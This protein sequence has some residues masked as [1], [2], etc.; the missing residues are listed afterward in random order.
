MNTIPPADETELVKRLSKGDES[1]FGLLYSHYYDDVKFKVLRM[2][3]S[4]EL[5]EDVTQEIFM[6]IWEARQ[7]IVDI[8]SFRAYL[9]TTARNH[10]IN[11]LKSAAR[12]QEGMREILSHYNSTTKA[13]EDAVQDNEY[14]KFLQRKLDEL[15]VRT[16]EIFRLC[17]EQSKSYKEV[18]E[19]LG[20]SRDAVKSR[21]V[22]A[23]KL[24]KQSAQ[25]EM[26][27]PVI[28]LIII[29]NNELPFTSCLLS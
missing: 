13:T 21:M 3:R 8:R 25:N 29:L 2:L 24:L 22:H 14:M 12:R 15:P 23:M 5:S 18:A 6:K 11:V 16:K 10:S 28:L 7:Q 9:L 1:A 20:I 17:R 19:A 27:L 4:P 26:D